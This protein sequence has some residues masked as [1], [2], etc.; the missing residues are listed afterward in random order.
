MLRQY[1]ITKDDV[2]LIRVS[3]YISFK[4]LFEHYHFNVGELRSVPKGKWG[5]FKRGH[6]G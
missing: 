2:S 1:G 6:K 3:N 4:S 5:Q